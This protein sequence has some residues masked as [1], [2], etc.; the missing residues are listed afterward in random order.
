MSAAAAVPARRRRW[1]TDAVVAIALVAVALAQV[2]V[3]L[4]IAPRPIG[5]F[6]AIA[7][8]APIAWRRTH[9]VPAAL[10]GSAVWLVP[11]DG[12]VLVGYVASLL[13]FYA[14]TAYVADHYLAA[15]TVLIG[16][17]FGIIGTA[18]QDSGIGD[19]AGALLGVLAPA[20]VGVL[21]RRQRRR[22]SRLEELTRYLEQER[23]RRERAAV[24]DE[25]A[26]IARELHDLVAHAISIIAV[27]ADAAEAALERD[28]ALA[29]RPLAAI[30]GSAGEAL[31]EMRRLLGV[32]RTDSS[33]ADL[34]PLPGLSQL[35]SLVARAREGG[36]PVELS[37]DGTPAQL[38]PSLDLSAYRILQEALTN[39]VKHA[40]GAPVTV[41]LSWRPDELV[42][43]VTDRGPGAVAPPSPD[44]HGLVG[45]RERV[46]IHG[47]DLRTGNAEPGGFGVHARLPIEAS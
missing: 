16:A 21:A 36:Q 10:V 23:D 2:L 15:A 40:P 41:A 29:Q 44:A 9:P 31:T 28:P 20:A 11:T 7:S 33:D 47:G 8:T 34:E 18:L 39:A 38:P 4:P 14:V 22:T 25:R 43:D 27:Q 30:R 6:V 32:L 12:Y 24:A 17:V 1:S 45:M 5:A 42:I 13:L 46:R 37:V 19:Y 3:F 26:R 35:P